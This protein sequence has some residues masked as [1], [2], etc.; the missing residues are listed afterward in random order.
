MKATI[1]Q[2]TPAFKPFDVT[3]TITSLQEQSALADALC[4]YGTN[5]GHAL[6]RYGR[7]IAESLFDAGV[8][9][10]GA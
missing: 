5:P 3:I 10:R 2:S 7:E 4:H 8:A 9:V 6:R 1:N